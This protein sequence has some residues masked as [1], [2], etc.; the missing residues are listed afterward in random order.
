[1]NLYFNGNQEPQVVNKEDFIKFL[2]NMVSDFETFNSVSITIKTKDM[3]LLESAMN[4]QVNIDES[5]PR[6]GKLKE[7]LSNIKMK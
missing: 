3:I 4:E 7:K 1:M 2:N 6:Y 5:D